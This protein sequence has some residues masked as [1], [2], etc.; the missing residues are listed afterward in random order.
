M[1]YCT[2]DDVRL[3]Y[4]EHGEGEPVALIHGLGSSS[5]DWFAQV[6]YLAR[7]YRVICCDLRGHGRSSKPEGPYAIAQFAR[8][9]AVLLRTLDAAPAHVVG[10]SMGGMVAMELAAH[11]S[12]GRLVRS[13]VTINSPTD[14]R[15]RSWRDVWFYVS[16]RLAVQVLAMRRVGQIIAQRLFVKPEQDHL[17]REFVRRW[18]T[19]DASAYVAS[20]DAIMGWSVEDRLGDVRVPVLL[21]SSE[22]DYTPVAAKN[23]VAAR[24]ADAELAVV[25]DARHALPVERPDELN[26]ILGRFLA[27]QGSGS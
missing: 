11:P 14:V 5:R 23:R 21:V 25:D 13:V 17:R 20:V 9:V 26:P 3:Y 2:V 22:H 8:D 1:P 4:E 18:S 10:L 6:P 12:S 19:N 24:M 27:R 16:R 15:L 7:R